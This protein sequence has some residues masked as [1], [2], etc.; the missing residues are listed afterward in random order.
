MG[1]G[2]A[3]MGP[4]RPAEPLRPIRGTPVAVPKPGPTPVGRDRVG[5]PTPIVPDS[6]SPAP[7]RAPVPGSQRAGT[8]E[9]GADGAVNDVRTSVS[10]PVPTGT[11]IAFA[12]PVGTAE[13]T[14]AVAAAVAAGAGPVNPATAPLPLVTVD[15]RLRLVTDSL[16][17]ELRRDPKSA[18]RS[19]GADR[20][21]RTKTQ[22]ELRRLLLQAVGC[23]DRLSGRQRQVLVLR[24]GGGPQK[25]L[26]RGQVADRLDL[27]RRQVA[28]VERAVRDDLRRLAGSQAC[29]PAGAGSTDLAG[30]STAGTGTTGASL[31]VVAGGTTGAAGTRSKEINR[32]AGV[33]EGGEASGVAAARHEASGPILNT[34]LGSIDLATGGALGVA[35]AFAGLA[36]LAGLL[37][38]LLLSVRRRRRPPVG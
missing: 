33:S 36:G 4:A 6:R 32:V 35:L 11:G 1:G 25:P 10:G 26:S 8:T 16:L 28:R 34:P 38:S 21:R 14:A 5:P 19:V 23:A 30:A 15:G 7:R 31:G 13:A 29:G 18:V 27:P 20:Y 9:G 17:R 24:V 3:P 22:L 37:A 12:T 2:D